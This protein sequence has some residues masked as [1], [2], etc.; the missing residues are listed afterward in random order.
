ME[1]GHENKLT[2][3]FYANKKAYESKLYRKIWNVGGSRSSKTVS[4]CQLLALIASQEKKSITITSP[5]LP[6]L[7][8]GARRD[9]L[10]VLH[11]YGIYRDADFNMTDNIY[12]FPSGSYAEFVGADEPGK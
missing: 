1:Q 6:H 12:H 3:V 5:S 7:K 11:N 9:F 10:Q 2:P 4:V 8:R